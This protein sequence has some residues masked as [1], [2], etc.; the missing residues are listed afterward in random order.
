MLKRFDKG[1]MEVVKKPL[2][3]YVSVCFCSVS[4]GF[5]NN[6]R[7]NPPFYFVKGVV[8]RGFAPKGLSIVPKFPF[9]YKEKGLF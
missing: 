4:I 6:P 1:A 8:D 5:P 7:F 3:F 2:L 9:F